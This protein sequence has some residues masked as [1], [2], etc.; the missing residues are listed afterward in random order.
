MPRKRSSGKG[1]VKSLALDKQDQDDIS[2][3]ET[4][5]KLSLFVLSPRISTKEEAAAKAN[6]DLQKWAISKATVTSY[7]V[8]MK[9]EG[10][11]PVTGAKFTKGAAVVPLFGVKLECKPKLGLDP[12]EFRERL[13]DDMRKHAPKYKAPKRRTVSGD[14]AIEP[15]LFDLHF[16]KLAWGIE[17]G[18][19]W[20]VGLADDATRKA[21]DELFGKTSHL[22]KHTS[23]IVL[24]IGND[25]LHTDRGNYFTTSGTLLEADGRW[26]RSFTRARDANVHMIDLWRQVAPVRVFIVSGN[27]DNE[28]MFVMGCVLEA[29]YR[30]CEDVIVD[31]SPT[32]RKLWSW[33]DVAVGFEHGDKNGRGKARDQL[34]QK[35]ENEFRERWSRARWRE[36]H[37]GHYHQEKEDIH[38]GSNADHQAIVRTIP[39]LSATDRY[40]AEHGWRGIPN[41]EAHVWHREKGKEGY[42]PAMG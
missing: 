19:N 4:D 13:L 8:G 21:T 32:Y 30:N 9:V 34:P 20:D 26:Q 36:I 18:E 28:R 23:E 15:A 12:L 2:L 7:E 40:H 10:S 1:L 31:N 6:I 17:T 11:N 39:S 35:F 24:P 41:A 5:E 42:F 38:K 3:E 37:V 29:W 22:H 25:Q 14:F 33:G 16:G 27:H